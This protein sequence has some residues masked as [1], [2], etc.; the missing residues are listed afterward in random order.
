MAMT[1]TKA[2]EA[3]EVRDEMTAALNAGADH[4]LAF[5]AAGRTT[6]VDSFS[7]ED[8]EEWDASEELALV[9]DSD[10]AELPDELNCD[11]AA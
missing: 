8:W 6:L 4:A 5:Y 11:L 9:A 3:V 1:A 2:L 10:D 7:Q